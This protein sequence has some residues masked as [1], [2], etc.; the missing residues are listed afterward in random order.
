MI[1]AL[2]A[3]PAK[4]PAVSQALALTWAFSTI[5]G[6]GLYGLQ[7]ALEF[8]R[9][10]GATVISTKKPEGVLLPALTEARLA[11][12]FALAR[13]LAATLEQQPDEHLHFRHPVLHA[14]GNDF[15]IVA[16][17]DHVRGE[18]NIGCAAIEHKIISP[19]GREVAA[20]YDRLIAISRWNEDFLRALNLAPVSLCYQGIDSALFHPGPASGLWR[21]SFVVFSGGKFEF[22][23]GQDIATAAFK[24]FQARH[25]E[26]LLVACWQNLLPL[27]PEPFALAGHCATL[28]VADPAHGLDI[29]RWLL[30]QG[31]PQSSFI[32]L[33]YTP[34][35]LMP[36]VLR[37]C[38]AAIFPNRCEGGTNLVA[39]EAMACG[40]PTYVAANT[41]Q[42]DLVA[43]FACGAF[44]DQRP[45]K[46]APAMASVEDWG[47]TAV[48]EVV[49]ALERLY[50]QR[51][52]ARA[53]ALAC[54]DK[55]KAYDWSAVNAKL[56]RDIRTEAVL[57]N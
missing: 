53:A 25:P 51:A 27:E 23:K 33:P 39:M 9:Q 12:T 40:V 31:L 43:L 1:D 28:P 10:G 20:G 57:T 17:S 11:P 45:V 49:E 56:L 29:A 21:D 8:L 35:M 52:T 5:S 42:R 22:R 41:G 55:L 26:A 46:A 48:E 50:T 7:I 54:A 18:P 2:P 15:T 36:F 14:V 16:G 37:E 6:Y 19:H 34:N 4:D 32:A 13:K 24:I 30:E 47:E 3:S 44:T 38:D